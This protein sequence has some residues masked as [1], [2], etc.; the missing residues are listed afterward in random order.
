[1]YNNFKGKSGYM[2]GVRTLSGYLKTKTGDR[3]IVSM[4]A[5]NFGGKVS[6][7]DAIHE[8]IL[9]YLYEKY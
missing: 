9:M 3:I 8:E 5:N 6:P 1:M 2:S 4:A 7:I